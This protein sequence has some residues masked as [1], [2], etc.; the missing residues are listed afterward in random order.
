[1]SVTGRVDLDKWTEFNSSLYFLSTE[2]G[3][4]MKGRQDCKNRDADLV[5]IDSDEEQVQFFCPHFCH[6]NNEINIMSYILL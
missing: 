4:W 2:T 6:K 5:V 1:M 3:S